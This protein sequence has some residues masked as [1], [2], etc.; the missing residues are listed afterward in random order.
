[1]PAFPEHRKKSVRAG[2]GGNRWEGKAW[3]LTEGSSSCNGREGTLQT[4]VGA[5]SRHLRSEHP[6]V[7]CL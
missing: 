2:Q 3:G 4:A 7:D 5:S 6:H 1:M